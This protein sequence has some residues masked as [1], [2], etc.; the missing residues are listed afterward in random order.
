MFNNKSEEIVYENVPSEFCDPISMTMI[1]KPI[2]LP[3]MD[4][5]VEDM[6]AIFKD[7]EKIA[8]RLRLGQNP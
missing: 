4:L 8:V 7:K 5:I 3:D 6:V 2:M 1:E